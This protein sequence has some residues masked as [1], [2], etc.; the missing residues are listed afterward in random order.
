MA[1][2]FYIYQEEK[3]FNC[4]NCDKKVKWEALTI[5]IKGV[6]KVLCWDC[7]ENAIEIIQAG[8]NEK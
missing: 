3:S 5:Y 6:Q 1:E 7:G 2:T 4:F 8:N